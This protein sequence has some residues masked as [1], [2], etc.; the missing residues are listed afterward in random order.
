MDGDE[1]MKRVDTVLKVSKE[2]LNGRKI[3]LKEYEAEIAKAESP[4]HIAYWNNIWKKCDQLGVSFSSYARNSFHNSLTEF[5]IDKA[6]KYLWDIIRELQPNYNFTEHNKP[7]INDLLLYF[8][9]NAKFS[10]DLK[11]G[12]CL[13]GPPGSGKTFLM[14]CFMVFTA[15]LKYK[16]FKCYHCDEVVMKLKSNIHLIDDYTNFPAM[17]DD[18][19]RSNVKNIFGDD[20]DTMQYILKTR[21][22]KTIPTHATT[23]LN[24]KDIFNRC[25]DAAMI[26]R[27][28]SMFNFIY[29]YSDLDYR[30]WK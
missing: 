20:I 7:V 4:E 26:S 15:Q 10:G 8:T 28:K 22:R 5:P 19:F 17:L 29:L 23:M 16:A 9:G 14:S 3:T 25:E 27:M 24:E 1:L 18:L 30:T 6:K 2:V 12:I 21:Q 11:K 13:I